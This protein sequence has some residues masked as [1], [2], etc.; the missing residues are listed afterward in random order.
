MW[1]VGWGRLWNT[2]GWWWGSHRRVTDD[3]RGAVPIDFHAGW[4]TA[5][6]KQRGC[7][8]HDH[9]HSWDGKFFIKMYECSINAELMYYSKNNSHTLSTF[10]SIRWRHCWN[11]LLCISNTLWA[12]NSWRL[13]RLI[14]LHIYVCACIYTYIDIYMMTNDDSLPFPSFP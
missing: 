6:M 4:F 11:I 13:K 9:T 7:K 12:K 10:Y 1:T 3:I 2:V 14:L 5:R 8:Q